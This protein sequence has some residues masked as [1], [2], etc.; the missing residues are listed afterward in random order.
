M[1]LV[2]AYDG[3]RIHTL[4]TSLMTSHKFIITENKI[5]ESELYLLDE[6]D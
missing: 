6:A 3:D 2:C 1:S 5:V 4:H